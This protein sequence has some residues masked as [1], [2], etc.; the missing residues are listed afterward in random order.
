MIECD[1]ERG[2]VIVAC[3]G[4]NLTGKSGKGWIGES[5]I[6]H[7]PHCTLPAPVSEPTTQRS[8][9]AS[10]VRQPALAAH[11]LSSPG[12]LRSLIAPE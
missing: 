1:T 4:P 6:F 2:S 8:K 7:R 9:Q 12:E 3:P 10:L 5:Y 11:R